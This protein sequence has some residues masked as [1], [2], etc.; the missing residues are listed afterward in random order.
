MKL[1]IAFCL[2]FLVFGTLERLFPLRREQ[3]CFRKNWLT[4]VA[5]FFINHVAINV[6][7]FAIGVILYVLFH[8][9]IDPT[10]QTAIR[11]QPPL[12]QFL[13]AFFLAQ[14]IFYIIHRAAHTLPW[15]WRF[16]AIHHSSTE[17][18]WLASAR[19]HPMEMI[20]VNLATGVPL[21]W[22]GF[23]KETFGA[24]LIVGAFLPIFNHANIK[25]RL[26]I[27]RWIIATPEYHH[28][29]HSND[30]QARDKNFAGL[31]VIDLMF[32]TFYLPEQKMPKTYGVD[33]AIPSGYWR[34]ML[35]PFKKVKPD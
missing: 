34:Q 13:E 14:L 18:D 9:S 26:P 29:H 35:Y 33:E 11:S 28:W 32:G 6:G 27:L 1:A 4:D 15:L 23:T 5:H 19:L 31:P 24:Y 21:F 3:K 2:L 20:L 30:P 7:T 16:H 10:L 25:V 17:L 22:L 8:A 12:L